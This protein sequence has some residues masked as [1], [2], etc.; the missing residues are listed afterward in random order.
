[1]KIESQVRMMRMKQMVEYTSLSRGYIFQKINEGTF[2]PGVMI[3]SGVR[4]WQKS[5]IDNWISK[6]MGENA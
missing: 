5:D 6:K 2:P 1:M 4:A 3:S